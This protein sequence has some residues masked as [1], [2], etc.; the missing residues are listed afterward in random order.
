M[1]KQ[2]QQQQQQQNQQLLLQLDELLQQ[3]SQWCTPA[4]CYV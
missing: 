1:V 3:L 4:A 2:Q